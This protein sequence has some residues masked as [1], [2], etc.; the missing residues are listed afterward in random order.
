VLQSSNPHDIEVLLKLWKT[1]CA[2]YG[3][4]S[5]SKQDQFSVDATAVSCQETKFTS[6]INERRLQGI[7]KIF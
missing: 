1:V 2:T 4:T 7:A 6:R 3:N 5:A